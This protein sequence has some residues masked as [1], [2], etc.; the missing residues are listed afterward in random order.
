MPFAYY[1]ASRLQEA[2]AIADDPTLLQE[3]G[4]CIGE[5]AGY[6]PSV[7]EIITEE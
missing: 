4:E 2:E 6:E 7:R 1:E 5:V 3:K